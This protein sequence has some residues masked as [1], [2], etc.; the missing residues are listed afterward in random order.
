MAWI[1]PSREL[2][3]MV[4]TQS[5]GGINPSARFRELVNAAIR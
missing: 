5:P 4:F 1:D 3:G 2:V